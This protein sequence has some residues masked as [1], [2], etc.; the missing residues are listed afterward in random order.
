VTT[1]LAI[2]PDAGHIMPLQAENASGMKEQ[3]QTAR[4]TTLTIPR[5]APSA[6]KAWSIVGTIWSAQKLSLTTKLEQLQLLMLLAAQNAEHAGQ[7]ISSLTELKQPVF[8]VRQDFNLLILSELL[9][10][11]LVFLQR[12]LL[13]IANICLDLNLHVM[14]VKKVLFWERMDRAAHKK[15]INIPL[16]VVNWILQGIC[17]RLVC[18]RYQ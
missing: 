2:A 7:Q 17:A 12:D 3:F 6:K 14:S 18:R 8:F 16:I 15:W 9:I 13:Q 1:T 4:S 10:A 11:R 5:N